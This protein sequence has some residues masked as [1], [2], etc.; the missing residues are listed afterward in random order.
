MAKFWCDTV[1]EYDSTRKN[2]KRWVDMATEAINKWQLS[3]SQVKIERHGW[4]W[5]HTKAYWLN[6]KSKTCGKWKRDINPNRNE[7]EALSVRLN[8]HNRSKQS[9]WDAQ[10]YWYLIPLVPPK[11]MK[12]S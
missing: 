2:A 1:G 6:V 11:G 9:G 3:L 7:L 5:L 12:I 10:G 4:F 8:G